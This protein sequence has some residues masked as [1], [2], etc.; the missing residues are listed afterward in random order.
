MLYVANI[1]EGEGEPPAALDAHARRQGAGCIAVS[2]RVEA[3]WRSSPADEA[4]EMRS[5]LGL[6]EAGLERV[7]RAAYELLDLITFFTAHRGT[8]A[9][10]RALRRGLDR[11]RGRRRVHTDIQAGFVRAEVIGWRELVEAGGYAAARERGLSA[12][13]AATTSSPTAT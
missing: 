6:A 7:V 11:L 3:S 1:D 10:A 2:A 5:E 8:E 9:T 4:A 13:R 12:P